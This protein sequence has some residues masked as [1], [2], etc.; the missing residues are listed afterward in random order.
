MERFG[1]MH[2][3]WSS[4]VST[5]SIFSTTVNGMSRGV[6]PRSTNGMLKNTLVRNLPPAEH[7][8]IMRVEVE[9]HLPLALRTSATVTL[10]DFFEMCRTTGQFVRIF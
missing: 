4:N 1:T 10:G 8:F 9:R 3:N 6:V 2:R 7:A 5:R